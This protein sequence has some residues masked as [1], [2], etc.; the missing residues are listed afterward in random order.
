MSDIG[1]KGGGGGGG[2]DG[3]GRTRVVAIARKVDLAQV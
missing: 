3:C 1:S 2:G